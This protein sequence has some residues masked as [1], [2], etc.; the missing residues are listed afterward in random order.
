MIDNDLILSFIFMFLLFIRQI[1]ILKQANKIDYAPLILGIGAI[2]SIVHFIIHPDSIDLILLLRESSFPILISLFL[3]IVMNIIHQNQEAENS[4]NNDRFSK[5]LV[6]EITNL[7]VFVS[8]LENKIYQ[9][10]TDDRKAQQEIM[11]K[12]S[13]DIKALDTIKFNQSKFL[14]KF[15]EMELWHKNVSKEFENFTKEQMP[16]LDN[17]VHKHIDILRIAEQDHYNKIKAVLENAV[18]SRSDIAE[19]M[20]EMKNN[21]D[22]MKD[23]A[24]KVANSITRATLEKLSD[25]TQSFENQI[26]SLKSHSEGIE[27]SL[28][29]GENAL[30]TIRSESEIIMKQ[31]ILSSNRMSEVQEQNSKLHNIYTTI[32]ELMIDIEAIKGDYVKSQSQ[33]SVIS[34]ELQKTENEQFDTMKVQ[35]ESLSELLIA[36]MDDSLEKLH[37]HYNIAEGDISPTL[38]ELTKRVQSKKSYS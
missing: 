36:K 11:I 10:N 37:E 16:E 21:L 29:E 4:K 28:S 32:K 13:Q 17:V 23:I 9:S 19:Y 8:D 14:D 1:S 18:E 24:D 20:Q 7:K 30:N 25:V 38:Q 3:Y 2:S 33:L 34:R 31:M 6:A 27:T 26:L 5:E 35:I 22:S 15:D 12:F